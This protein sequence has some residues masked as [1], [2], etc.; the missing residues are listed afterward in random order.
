MLA[1]STETQSGLWR[2]PKDTG[3]GAGTVLRNELL[4]SSVARRLVDRRQESAEEEAFEVA[5]PSSEERARKALWVVMTCL[6]IE[7]TSFLISLPGASYHAPEVTS[8]R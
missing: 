7:D 5:R 6:W 3:P 8:F 4:R 2:V 1:Q